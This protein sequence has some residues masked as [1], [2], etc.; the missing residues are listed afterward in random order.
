VSVVDGAG[1]V[2]LTGNL[3]SARQHQVVGLAWTDIVE[4][5]LLANLDRYPNVSAS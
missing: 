5:D 4:T 3:I 1:P 2:S